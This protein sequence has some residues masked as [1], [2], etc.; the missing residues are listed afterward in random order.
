MSKTVLNCGYVPLVDCAPLVIAKELGF[1]AEEALVLNL[2]R[3]P[4]WSALRDMLALGHLDA[5]QMLSPMPVA[6]S[7]G[8][9]GLPA[10]V[11]TL[12]VLSVNGTVFGVSNAL[13]SEMG[14]VPFGDANAIL[15][16][17]ST[18]KDKSLRIGVPFHYSMHR[19]LL[20][21][22]SSAA[23]EL[24]I[25]EIT[26]A[27]QRMADAVADGFVD[28]FWVGEPWG[29]VAVQKNVAQLAM[30]GRDV[31]QFA[32]EKVLAAR[33]DWVETNDEAARRLMRA[34]FHASAWLDAPKNKSLA[35]EILGRSEHL[36]VSP[37]L[38]DPAL[39]GHIVPRQNA[40]PVV[41]DRF[42]QF[43]KYAA[44]FPWRSQAA[45]IAHQLGADAGGIEKAKAC[46]RSDLYRQ[47]LSGVG[48]D[49]PGASEKKEGAL[50]YES[51]VASTRG[52][53]ILAPDAFFDGR[54]FDFSDEQR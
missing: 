44:S 47:N 26:V 28:A 37:D 25:E 41:V 35:V 14:T 4:S 5:A 22:W 46:F 13:A 12:M 52:H 53:M 11:D 36:S 50:R 15:K 48:A 21:Y 3:Q 8:F 17:L 42:L 23:P 43:H 24:R 9:G 31:W 10:R 34:V 45:W 30:T 2:V 54:T 51:A 27:P 38:I 20:S 7:I 40:T 39:T 6:M 1:A 32:P 19:L 18:R 49:M 33:H 16:A 29:S